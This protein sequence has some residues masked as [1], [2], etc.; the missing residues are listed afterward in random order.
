M[1]LQIT[2]KRIKKKEVINKNIAVCNG[3]KITKGNNQ[4]STP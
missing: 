1:H 2:I 3:E 4:W